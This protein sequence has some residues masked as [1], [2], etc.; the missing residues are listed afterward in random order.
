MNGKAAQNIQNWSQHLM[1]RE[2]SELRCEIAKTL[3]EE[4][5]LSC[6]LL[7][8]KLKEELKN[9]K[10]RNT[11]LGEQS[12]YALLDIPFHIDAKKLTFD[13]FTRLIF[14]CGVSGDEHNNDAKRCYSRYERNMVAVHVGNL[15]SNEALEYSVI[16]NLGMLF[17]GQRNRLNPIRYFKTIMNTIGTHDGKFHT[18]EA[19][20]CF[21]LKSLPQFKD[22]QIIRSRNPKTLETCN[23]VIDVGGV[24]DHE[25]KRYDHHQRTFT[26]TMSSLNVLPNFHT[27]LSSAGLVYAYYGK[28]AIMSILNVPEQTPEIDLLYEKMYENFV[29]AVDAV[30]NGISRCKCTAEEK[31]YKKAESLDSRVADLVPQWNAEDQ[32]TDK[33]FL[34]AVALTG[35]SF[36][37]KLNYYYNA[38]LP[39]RRLVETAVNERHLFH[40]SGKIIHFP[41]GGL[42]WKS[43]LSDLELELGLAEMDILFAIYGDM[44]GTSYRVQTIPSRNGD[45]FGFK[46]GL[47]EEW[48][49]VRDEDL[50]KLSGIN[51][52]IFVHTS[53]FIGGAKSLDGAIQMAIKTMEKNGCINKKARNEDD[54]VLTI[55]KEINQINTQVSLK[56]RKSVTFH[57]ECSGGTLNTS[58]KSIGGSSNSL[59]SDSMYADAED[60]WSEDI[61][62]HSCTDSD[63]YIPF[64]AYI[65]FE[66]I[67]A[68]LEAAENEQAYA[69]LKDLLNASPENKTDIQIL[70]RLCRVCHQMACLLPMKDPKKKGYLYEGKEYGTTAVKLAETN[71]DVLK[72]AAACIG[73]STDFMGTK[74]KIETGYYFKELLDKAL[75]IDPS[76]FSLLHMR[77]RF[78]FSVAALSWL[79]RKAASA[80]Y[81]TP[82]TAT[83]NEALTDFLKVEETKNGDWLENLLFIARCYYQLEDKG[84]AIKFLKPA[85]EHVPKGDG[86]KELLNEVQA[87]MKKC[88]K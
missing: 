34:K 19:F 12:V 49:G 78:S 66:K 82:P 83:Y 75:L 79:E 45:A 47:H 39:A 56:P 33:P 67:D 62:H 70:W 63:S 40:E 1:K 59:N 76:E 11:A 38:W 73:A 23:I 2:C 29:E 36:T 46:L 21:L 68:Q 42:P 30:D 24:F 88:S 77:G 81:A 26:E 25:T 55:K 80:F 54:E 20:G 52:A 44:S 43:H 4:I 28:L 61:V 85:A 35:D 74:D 37:T 13:Q 27:K 57:R 50:G 58:R 71:L 32:D 41:T 16:I 10:S 6:I 64:S 60:E 69:A 15:S 8:P 31:A 9:A 5:N 86:D 51:D 48:R 72:W 84:A 22:A 53:G 87:L 17:A 14:Y 65:D 18:D 7:W 3:E